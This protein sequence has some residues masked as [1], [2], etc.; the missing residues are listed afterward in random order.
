MISKQQTYF[1]N[2]LTSDASS[3]QVS[4]R[5]SVIMDPCPSSFS[6]TKN[7]LAF[8]HPFSRRSL[9]YRHRIPH[10]NQQKNAEAKKCLL[11]NLKRIDLARRP[12]NQQHP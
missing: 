8:S 7:N 1:W 2:L 3:F 6:Y 4:Y 12:V 9:S 10:N 11:V 5:L